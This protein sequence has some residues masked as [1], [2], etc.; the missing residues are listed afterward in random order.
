MNRQRQNEYD[1]I[2]GS[3]LSKIDGGIQRHIALSNSKSIT[4]RNKLKRLG[5][6]GEHID[7]CIQ[8]VDELGIQ[9]VLAHQSLSVRFSTMPGAKRKPIL[10][11]P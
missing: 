11:Q 2:A 5:L 8:M 10:H 4:I 6:E 7:A 9:E 1:R 3:R